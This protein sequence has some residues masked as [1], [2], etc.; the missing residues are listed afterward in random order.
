MTIIDLKRGLCLCLVVFLWAANAVAQDLIAIKAGRL[1]DGTGTPAIESAIILVRGE[2]IESVGKA[3]SITIP[4]NARVIDLSSDTVMPGMINGHD[5]PSVRAFTG[6]EVNREGR[7]SLIQQLNQ[8][9]EPTAVQ[10][11]RGVRDL[12]V[13]LLSGVTTEYVVG[14]IGYDDMYLKEM[15]DAGVIPGPRMYLSGPWIIP[16]AGYDPI[17]ETN[18]PW[19]MRAM[20]RKNVQ[21]GAHHIKIVISRGMASGPSAGRPYGPG[22]TNFTK[23]EL[24]AVVDEAHRLGVK[25]TAHATDAVS[26]KLALD[27][28]VDS[29]QHAL[30]LTPEIIA[31]FLQHHAGVVNTYAALLQTYFTPQDFHYLD[32]EA[33]SPDDWVAHSQNLIDR[34]IAENHPFRF[35]GNETLQAYLNKR[36]AQ[37]RMAR[38]KGV[39]IAVGTDNMQGLLDIEIEHLV[40]AGFTPLEAISAATGQGAKVL[41]IEDEVGTLE[42]GKFADIISIRGKPDQNIQDLRKVEFIMVSG[43]IYSNLSFR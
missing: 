42:K 18:G 40:R 38:D 22:A 43:K 27:A 9:G 8:M 39:P 30:E 12:R 13:D 33:H 36:Y 17:P 2:R 25:V 19:A 31:L 34:V 24:E 14:E 32:T 16:T 15:V 29:I 5:H 3:S 10:V 20:V 4:A 6:G 37:L 23:E 35:S 7:N 1:F 11:A 21:A 28:G 41:G 26:T